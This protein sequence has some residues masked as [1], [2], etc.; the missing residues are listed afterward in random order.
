MKRIANANVVQSAN[1]NTPARVASW[2][3]SPA[4]ILAAA[5]SGETNAGCAAAGERQQAW[6]LRLLR[7]GRAPRPPRSP[8]LHWCVCRRARAKMERR[9][10]AKRLH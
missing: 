1:F 8:P 4:C 5:G 7:A 10:A 3:S 6:A 2:A 9:G